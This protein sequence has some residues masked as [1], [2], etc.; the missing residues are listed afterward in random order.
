MNINNTKYRILTASLLVIASKLLL[1]AGLLKGYSAYIVQPFLW[2]LAFFVLF[3]IV[4]RK[5]IT[6]YVSLL[7][8]SINI[9][10]LMVI[11]VMSNWGL[12]SYDTSIYGIVLNI[13][14]VTPYVLGLEYLR[15][16]ILQRLRNYKFLDRNIVLVSILFTAIMVSLS[17]FA[18]SFSDETVMLKLIISSLLPLFSLNLFLSY[19]LLGGGVWNTVTFSLATYV[20]TFI[21]PVLPSIPWY[22]EGIAYTAIYL[23]LIIFTMLFLGEVGIPREELKK[24]TLSKRIVGIVSYLLIIAVLLLIFVGGFKPFVIASGSMEPNINIG[25]IVLV[26]SINIDE[27]EVGDIIAYQ[28]S[29]RIV[30]H[31]VIEVLNNTGKIYLKTKGDANSD[32]DPGLVAERVVLGKIT[33]TIPRI[34]LIALGFQYI[35]V[36]YPFLIP[37]LIIGSLLLYAI[38]ALV[39]KNIRKYMTWRWGI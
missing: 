34:G 2:F 33:F 38:L 16:A 39:G 9:G 8:A 27:V 28:I 32:A 13:L 4:D 29:N 11:G 24:N 10:A 19:L 22:I 12:N 3:D 7:L 31:R 5:S 14:R 35:M 23:I 30:V 25:D 26:Q 1:Y 21:A 18:L 15:A 36:N 6:L 17:K 20:F 37:I